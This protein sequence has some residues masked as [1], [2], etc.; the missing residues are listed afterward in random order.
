M[1]S[2]RFNYLS[3]SHDSLVTHGLCN[4]R[5]YEGTIINILWQNLSIF[6][7]QGINKDMKFDMSK[8]KVKA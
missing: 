4:N 5:K 6:Y 1:Q 2:L 7:S 3:V 8:A